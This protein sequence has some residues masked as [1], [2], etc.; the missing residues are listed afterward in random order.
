V[1][2]PTATQSTTVVITIE[3]V[4]DVLELHG[5]EDAGA[6]GLLDDLDGLAGFSYDEF[7]S[8]YLGV[9][10]GS[11]R[12]LFGGFSPDTDSFA[13]IV[14]DPATQLVLGEDKLF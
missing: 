10:I 6:P 11:V 8:D 4:A 5:I 9:A 7:E 1:P 13:D 2:R 12:L 3:A 14:D